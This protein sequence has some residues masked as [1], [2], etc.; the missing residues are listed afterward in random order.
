MVDEY[1]VIGKRLPRIDAVE[2][3]TGTA[4]YLGDLKI[5][6]MLYG[7][8]LRSPYSH[9]K[10]LNVDTSKAERLRG[11]RAAVTGKD[12]KGIRIC[13]I[14]HLANKPPLAENQ[15]RFIGDEVAAVAA[16]SEEIAE[17]ALDLIEVEY[18]E[19]PSVFDPIEAMK[20][21]A[22]KI[23]E[24]G[25]VANHISRSYGDVENALA[26]SDYVFEDHFETQ[27]QHHCCLETRGCIAHFD[28]SGN[29]TVWVTTQ[30]PHPYR[31]MLAD[32]L[33]MS[34]NKIRI[35][36]VYMGGGFGERLEVDPIDV[37]TVFLSKKTGRPVRIIN[38]RDEQF[39]TGRTR[40]PMVIDIKTG[41]KK[42]GTLLAREVRVVTDNGAYNNQ[43]TAIT[44]G[45]GTKCSY[46]WSIPNVKFE[47]DVVFTNKVYGGGFRGY[48]NPQI[49][50]AIESQMDM[51]AEKLGIDVKDLCLKNVNYE[52]QITCV[53][54]KV[55][56]CGLKD[57]IE[58][59]VGAIGWKDKRRKP[60]KC[61]VGIA[62]VMH[63]GGG[64]RLQH[65]GGSNL[66]DVFIKMNS[67]G[68]I[69][70]ASGMGE[71]GQGSDTIFAQIAAE[72]LGLRLDDIRVITGDTSATPQC[73]GAWGSREVFV[74]GNAV[75]LA[76][77]EVR[78]KLFDEASE[79]LGA[80]VN[81]LVLRDKMV[82][83][84][85][86]LEKAVSIGQI[87]TTCYAKGEI[88]AA[89]VCYDA[90]SPHISDRNVGSGLAYGGSPTFSFG[91]QTVEVEV[92]EKTGQVKVL[93]FVAAHDIGRVINPLTAEGQIEGAIAQGLGY[94][95]SEGFIWEEGIVLNPNFQD[96]RVFYINDV[97]NSKTIL[98]ESIDPSGP[99]GAKGLG[100]MGMVP[101]A[102]AVANAIYDAVGV[103]I[104]S[105]P[106]TS[107]KI[108]AALKEKTSG[109]KE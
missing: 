45:V 75:M 97:P 41:V 9:A 57:C 108:L 67:D 25:N 77:E 27:A 69:D 19:L 59:A 79:I 18:E 34:L 66:S 44:N 20:P 70:L 47:G 50:F 36:K 38:T 33:G 87:V 65:K 81:D 98:I 72:T 109:L 60:G 39:T 13:V 101:T 55:T 51:I 63:T 21:G 61:G 95:L 92:N 30:I 82:Y 105:L 8:I 107:E 54:D 40:Y 16:D 106:I 96:Y 11:V 93:K 85:G 90:P 3:A 4:E 6:G 56:S 89:R 62:S 42:D 99:Y 53:G 29:L 2:K 48:G 94:A 83:V 68:T 26:E 76:A 71:T 31:K 58:K 86:H 100:E 78:Q 14:P 17:D 91:T 28:R 84:K 52:G 104:K 12:T 74:G 80:S 46:L 49:T 43:G 102:A 88:P 5:S 64:L 37:I 1:S 22:V 24:G 35:I 103:R 73:M 15:V 7:K 32:M 23:H 10:V